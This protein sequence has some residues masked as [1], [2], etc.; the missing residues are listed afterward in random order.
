MTRSSRITILPLLLLALVVPAC[1]DVDGDDDSVVADD[2][3]LI[4]DD[5]S[6]GADDDD[7]GGAGDPIENITWQ[8][9]GTI[10]SLIVVSWEQLASAAVHLE[11]RVDD[12]WLVSPTRELDAGDQDELLL[13]VPYDHDVT[14]RIV[15]DR[16]GDLWTSEEYGAHT[17]EAP[18]GVFVASLLES[19]ATQWEPT[20]QYVLAVVSWNRGWTLIIDRQARLV[21]ATVTTQ[22]FTSLYSRPSYDGTDILVDL[23]SYWTQYDNG[24][25]SQIQRMKIDGTVVET[26]DTPG[27]HHPFVELADGTLVWGAAQGY[28]ETVEKLTPEGE[29]ESLWSCQDF[30]D[31]I[32]V[33]HYCQSNTLFWNEADDTFLLSLYS[34]ETIVEFDHTTGETVR[35]FGH[36]PGS[37]TFDPPGS[38]FH[39]QHGGHYTDAGTLITSSHVTGDSDE[40]VV[41]EYSLNEPDETL[42]E[43][44]SYGVGLGVEADVMG[45]VHR[46]PAGNTLH[47]YGSGGRLKEVLPD[48]TVVWDVLW[49]GHLELGRTTPLQGLYELAP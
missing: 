35:Y 45:E 44:W 6:G 5:D 40:C 13:G 28:M 36:M 9:H 16:D 31:E 7:S 24:A 47:N 38:A 17:G 39:W 25:A 1:S 11:F 22:E 20:L 10:G 41:R 2:D 29:Q 32:G 26:Y 21:W 19:D 18:Q 37:W 15:A 8:V 27:L 14:F 12:D 3:D 42:Y 34:D 30:H 49:E 33:T 43:V 48:G 46:L 23:N 4:D